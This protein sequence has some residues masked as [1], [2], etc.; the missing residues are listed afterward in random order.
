VSL[1]KT[2][3]DNGETFSLIDVFQTNELP[4][5]LKEA[6]FQALALAFG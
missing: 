6:L 2:A 4:N 5:D 3:I 1:V